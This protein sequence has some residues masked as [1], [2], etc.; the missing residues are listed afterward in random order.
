[1]TKRT[2]NFHG[3]TPVHQWL[4][5][6]TLF[7]WGFSGMGLLGPTAQFVLNKITGD[8]LQCFLWLFLSAI[9]IG[10]HIVAFLMHLVG[11]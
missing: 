5:A 7:L 4:L 8:I 10:S 9:S 2:H 1:M 3:R 11:L 6:I